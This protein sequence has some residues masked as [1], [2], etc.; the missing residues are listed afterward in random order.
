[1]MQHLNEPARDPREINPELDERTARM[2]LKA[3]EQNPNDRYQ[4]MK[5]LV[6]ELRRLNGEA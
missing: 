4:G 6:T 2:V 1:M 5:E 3:L